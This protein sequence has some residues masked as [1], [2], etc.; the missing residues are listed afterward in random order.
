MKSNFPRIPFL[1]GWAQAKEILNDEFTQSLEEGREPEAV[2]KIRA[3]VE[4]L[5][6]SEHVRL[7]D[8]WYELQAIPQR[9]DF[10]FVKNSIRGERAQPDAA[11]PLPYGEAGLLDRML[12]AWQGRCVGC[13]LGKPIEGMM[14][15]LNGL[16]SKERIKTYLTAISP[17]EY[18]IRGYIPAASPASQQTGEASCPPSTR[19]KIAF[20]ETD[21][22]IRYTI[23]AQRVMMEQGS[24]FASYDVAQAWMNYLGYWHVC[25]AETQ[26]YRN[27]VIR[28]RFPWARNLIMA[29]DWDWVATHHNPYR[30]WIGA[31]I[32]ADSWGYA[33]PGNPELAADFAWRDARLSHV[34]NGI[35]GEM[36]CAAMIAAGFAIA[37][38][39]KVV[40]AGL[41]QIPSRSRL[42]KDMRETVEI[43]R[44]HGFLA[45][46]FEAVLD[47]IYARFG[48]YNPVHTN[49]NAA[50]VVAA[51]LLGQDDFEKAIGIAVMGGWDTDCNG[52]QR[53]APSG[54]RCT[55]RPGFRQN[56]RP[57]SMT[58]YSQEFS[59]T[60]PSP[61]ANVP[62][63]ASR[64]QKKQ[65]SLSRLEPA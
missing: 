49:N 2:E 47:K 45:M 9:A 62:G 40:E 57:R 11:F 58:H 13:A 46:E 15:P 25:T 28:Y 27:M 23:I 20:M 19:E 17:E 29:I 21:D 41:A 48:H 5:D 22:D 8:V 55:A 38:P 24:G 30:E 34:K 10:P 61:S 14:S 32:R 63:A 6:K 43:C 37:D 7:S 54:A 31:Q 36:F 60:I 35:Y 26:A 39:L 33:A 65:V 18:P 3:Q 64:S 56:G 4:A 50:L 51:L 12:G 59:T 53:S 1:G 52:A 44:E 16:S 42:Y